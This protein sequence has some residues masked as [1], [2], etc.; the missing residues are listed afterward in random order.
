MSLSLRSN[1]RDLSWDLYSLTLILLF[2]IFQ[3]FQWVNSPKFLDMYY[4]L[5]VV[6]GFELAGGYVAGAFWE[7]APVGRVH[8]YPP[9]LHIL[10]LFLVK[11]GLFLITVARLTECL[12]Y[13]SLLISL[14]VVIR[15][16]FSD[17][18]AFFVLMLW[19]SSYSLYLYT[20]TLPAFTLCLILSLWVV[21][22][23][24]EGKLL[25][26]F[27]LMGF[28]FY[29]H[30]AMSLILMITLFV[31]GFFNRRFFKNILLST[32]YALYLALPFI[33]FLLKNQEYFQINKVVENTL[34]EIDPSLYLLA[35]IGIPVCLKARGR[36][37]LPMCFVIGMIP[38]AFTHQARFTGGHGL[39][40]VILLGAFA[41]DQMSRKFEKRSGVMKGALGVL[42]L[43]F[44]LFQFIVPVLHWDTAHN[45]FKLK[46]FDRTAMHN[47]HEFSKEDL[48]GN[49]Q[50]I[51]SKKLYTPLVRE[52]EKHSGPGQIIWSN[53]PYAGSL[54]ALLANRFTSHA[55]LTEVAPYKRF[56]PLKSS[57]LSLWFKNPDGTDP[58]DYKRAKRDYGLREITRMDLAILCRNPRGNQNPQPIKP[59]MIPMPFLFLSLPLFLLGMG[60]SIFRKRKTGS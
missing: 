29:T 11:C 43:S 10:M 38:F 28:C 54:V 58:K 14:W 7:Y 39:I 36:A 6:R 50:P 20:V 9:F 60:L 24:M 27:I 17:R 49:E 23:I 35:L 5:S 55:M 4:H 13:L 19:S 46:F 25:G 18:I 2:G 16:L 12:L 51:Y 31:Y 3:A 21:L 53:S 56:D 15:R 44:L 57:T 1:S 47:I 45:T 32:L 26:P 30:L 52:V 40:G 48:R 33:S 34:L 42:G 37:L 22:G 41:L 8:L 59:A